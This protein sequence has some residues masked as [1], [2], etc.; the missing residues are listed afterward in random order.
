MLPE[1]EQ[2]VASA[3]EINP[4]VAMSERKPDKIIFFIRRVP[5]VF[6][7]F[8]Q[9]LANTSPAM[10]EAKTAMALGSGIEFPD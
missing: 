5:Y 9:N 4:V 8:S 7:L 6:L 2:V 10:A 1:I 3:A